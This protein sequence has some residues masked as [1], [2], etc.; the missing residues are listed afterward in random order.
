MSSQVIFQD[1]TNPIQDLFVLVK[2]TMF[3]LNT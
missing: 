3:F 1:E 2:I